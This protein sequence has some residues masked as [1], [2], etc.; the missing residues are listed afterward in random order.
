MFVGG[1]LNATAVATYVHFTLK[2]TDLLA[3]TCGYVA[4]FAA[5]AALCVA[6]ELTM[7]RAG[8]DWEA[9]DDA[10][11]AKLFRAF[12]VAVNKLKGTDVAD[13][14]YL[15]VGLV[16][17]IIVM[18]IVRWFFVP[19]YSTECSARWTASTPGVGS[20][21]VADGVCC[22][23]LDE[24]FEKFDYFEFVAYLSGNVLAAYKT[25]QLGA[26][27]LLAKAKADGSVEGGKKISLQSEQDLTV[28]LLPRNCGKRGVVNLTLAKSGP[29]VN[30]EA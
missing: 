3:L 30:D 7:Q 29:D 4:W 14:L 21:I 8:R 1:V 24:R 9:A 25:V 12:G 20:C 13:A 11:D 23:T 18:F 6:S 26:M 16:P 5:V 22:K 27:C 17:A 10:F 15:F 28:P 19:R 2:R